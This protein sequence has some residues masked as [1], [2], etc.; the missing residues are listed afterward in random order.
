MLV[1]KTRH[2]SYRE[3]PMR[4]AELG[5]VHRHELSGALHGLMRV[6]SF[7]QDDAHIF[8]LPS[9]IK[10]EIMGVMDLFN[11]VYSTF[12]LSYHA[13]LSTKPEKAMGSDEVWEV[14]TS[15]LQQALD[16]RN[17]TFRA[18]AAKFA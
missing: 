16:E 7:T 12:G 13:E 2:H 6:R 15:A 10:D 4:V 17:A 3:L 1:Y 11:V 9:Q 5:L 18:Y 14:A 8:M